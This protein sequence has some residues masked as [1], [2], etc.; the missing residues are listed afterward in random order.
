MTRSTLRL[1]LLRRT[2]TLDVLRGQYY[3]LHVASLRCLVSLNRTLAL[4]VV[5]TICFGDSLILGVIVEFATLVVFD[6][7][8]P[9]HY[10][11]F[12]RARGYPAAT[13]LLM[14]DD[15]PTS[16]AFGRVRS[17]SPM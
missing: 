6:N 8:L 9:L 14:C 2:R 7:V 1:L 15:R 17:A 11:F 5:E 13:G 16:V 3:G 4:L 12:V 10:F